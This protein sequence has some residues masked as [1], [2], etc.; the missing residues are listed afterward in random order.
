MLV[1]KKCDDNPLRALDPEIVVV[2]PCLSWAGPWCDICGPCIGVL[3]VVREM[4]QDWTK[5]RPGLVKRK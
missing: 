5:V 1:C 4:F 2:P 3:M